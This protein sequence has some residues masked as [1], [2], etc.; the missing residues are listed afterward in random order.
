V[1]HPICL[2]SRRFRRLLRAGAASLKASLGFTCVSENPYFTKTFFRKTHKW[3]FGDFGR[4][5]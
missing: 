3:H 1:K 4:L 2:L 5:L